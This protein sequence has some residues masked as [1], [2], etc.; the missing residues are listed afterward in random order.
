MGHVSYISVKQVLGGGLF[1]KKVIYF[2]IQLGDVSCS[3]NKHDWALAGALNAPPPPEYGPQPLKPHSGEQGQ[4][5]SEGEAAGCSS[6]QLGTSA[7]LDPPRLK[8]VKRVLARR[9][10]GNFIFAVL[11]QLIHLRNASKGRNMSKRGE[12]IYHD[13]IK[14]LR[15][16]CKTYPHQGWRWD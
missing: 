10:G 16:A 8:E 5:P 9:Q 14:T 1:F 7:H 13:A 4:I 15:F 3:Q 12:D 2:P 11:T 6:Q